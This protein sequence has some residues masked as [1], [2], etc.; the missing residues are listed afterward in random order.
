MKDVEFMMTN[1]QKVDPYKKVMLYQMLIPK[2]RLEY[3]R[4]LQI[5]SMVLITRVLVL[6]MSKLFLVDNLVYSLLG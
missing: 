3:L 5:I 2:V 4:T 6:N 1:I